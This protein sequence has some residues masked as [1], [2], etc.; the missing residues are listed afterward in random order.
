MTEFTVQVALVFVVLYALTAAWIFWTHAR[1]APWVPTPF[2]AVR[3]MLEI[4]EVGPGDLVYDLGSG[5]GRVLVI[6]AREFGAR[7]VGIELDLLRYAWTRSLLRVLRLREQARVIWGDF[8]HIDIG[9]A[10]VVILFLRQDTNELL[11][12]KLLL[13]LRPGTRV[14]SYKNTFL[15]WPVERKDEEQRIYMYRVGMR[16]A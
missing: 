14:V 15:G 16:E 2:A 12:V 10:D 9:Q 8:F 1:G 13:E 4:A 6:A 3:K 7:V 5:D 11:K